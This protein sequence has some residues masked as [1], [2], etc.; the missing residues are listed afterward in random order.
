MPPPELND[1]ERRA[2]AALER[3]AKCWPQT[4]TLLSYDGTL[5]VVHT[6]NK[7]VIADGY[8]PERQDLVLAHIDGIP[9]DG[10]SW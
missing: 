5:S 3:L 1:E 2:I 10:G 8:G 7:D 6:V 9:N 4:L